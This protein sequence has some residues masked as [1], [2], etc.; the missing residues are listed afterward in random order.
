[1]SAKR[2]A[3]VPARKR[4]VAIV[5]KRDGE[6]QFFAH[7]ARYWDPTEENASLSLPTCWGSLDVHEPGHRSQGADPTDPEQCV[8]ICRGHHDWVGD[9]PLL[10]KDLHL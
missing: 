6:C 1:M 2:R 8:A 5:L 9:H 7:V 4:C 10:A 3:Q